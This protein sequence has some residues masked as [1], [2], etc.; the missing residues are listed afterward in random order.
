VNDL[1][2]AAGYWTD[3][4]D[5]L[6][7]VAFPV[8]WTPTVTTLDRLPNDQQGD[9]TVITI[10]GRIFGRSSATSPA[11]GSAVYWHPGTKSPVKLTD[12][13]F[14]GGTSGWSFSRVNSANA[15]DTLAGSGTLSGV[16]KGFV[17]VRR[18]GSN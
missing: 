3:T 4:S 6:N 7:V 9:A 8:V 5:P 12:S 18:V 2:Q 16:E 14:F 13:H 17:M 15:L 1:R 10:S 11:N